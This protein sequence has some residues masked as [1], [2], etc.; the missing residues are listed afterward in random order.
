MV[1]SV[2][3]GVDGSA[4]SE[5]AAG[6]AAE[7]AH[8][9][10]R[11][12][13]MIHAGVPEAR[14]AEQPAERAESLPEPLRA[15]RDRLAAA[16]PESAVSCEQV[17]GDPAYALVAAGERAGLLVLGSRGLG[18]F[19]GLL[20]GSVGLRAAAHAACPVVLVR[21]DGEGGEDGEV[22]V[23]VEGGRPCDEALAFA[24]EQAAGRGVRLRA[25]QSSPPPAGPYDTEA[26]L[27]QREIRDSL[28]AS[29]LVRL[30]DALGRWRDKFP[31]VPVEAEVTAAP[32]ARALTEASRSAS[33][34]VVG[35]RLRHTRVAA[36]MLGP[37]THAVL[38]H[39]HSPV[40]VVPHV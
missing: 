4:A 29:E 18:G 32:A 21:A 38:H 39:A 17:P 20:V 30:Q 12:L 1:Q 24:F 11:S 6:W 10:G 13:R 31:A 25:L 2:V 28:A 40:A 26:P 36:P 35:R 14:P 16:L 23:G 8:R 7:Q 27:D 33:L 37:V 34:V 15:L 19:A 22:V 3:V 5:A 9:T